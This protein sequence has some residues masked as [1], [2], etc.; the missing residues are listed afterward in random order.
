MPNCKRVPSKRSC[1]LKRKSNENTKKSKRMENDLEK[2]KLF[3]KTYKKFKN[4][5]VF[6]LS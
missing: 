1:Q 6:I 4:H 2:T 3:I 5:F